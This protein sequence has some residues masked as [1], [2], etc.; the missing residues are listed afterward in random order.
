MFHTL[1]ADWKFGTSLAD[2]ADDHA[3][4]KFLEHVVER[5]ERIVLVSRWDRVEVAKFGQNVLVSTASRDE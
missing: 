3:H 2:R 5:I 4:A 1:L